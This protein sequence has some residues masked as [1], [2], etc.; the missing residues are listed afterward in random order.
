MSDL[1]SAPHTGAPPDLTDIE[2]PEAGP[3]APSLSGPPMTPQQ[4]IFFYDPAEW[5]LFIREWATG[6][7]DPYVQIK[8]LGGPSDRGV[9]V[10]GFKTDQGFEGA[11]DCYQGKHYADALTWTDTFPEMLKVFIATVGG[12][13]VLPDRYAF[14]APRGCG[15]SLNR[16]LSKPTDLRDRFLEELARMDGPASALAHD[17]REEVK[18]CSEA[19]DF[20]L[21]QSV[22]LLDALETHRATPYYVGRFGTPVPPRP[23]HDSPPEEVGTHEARYVGQLLEVYSEEEPSEAFAAETASTHGK[24]GG[25]FQRQRESFYSAEALRLYARDSVPPGTFEALQTDVFSGV[26]EVAESSHATGMSRLTSVLTTS[27]Q[28]DLSAHALISVSSIN[29]RKGI[30]HQLANEDRLIWVREES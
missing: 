29:D 18:A 19:T 28:L 26:V 30:C 10:A 23:G 8:R 5:E 11:W 12:H 22:E 7:G 16:L 6:L 3:V 15:P 17:L 20:A 25:H 21:F 14:L 2:V 1:A 4:H 27:G 13:Y 24:F 9:D